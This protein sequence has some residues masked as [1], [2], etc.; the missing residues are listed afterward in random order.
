MAIEYWES[1]I[2]TKTT[3][4][5]ESAD[6]AGFKELIQRGANLWPDA[7]ASIKEFADLV[8]SGTIRQDYYKQT[9]TAK[10]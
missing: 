9:N 10:S 7:P 1:K 5:I 6:L 2:F 8:T 3:V 4:T